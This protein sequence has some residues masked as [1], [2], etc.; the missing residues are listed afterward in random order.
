VGNYCNVS[1]RDSIGIALEA[2]KT[3]QLSNIIY[4]LNT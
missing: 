4:S 1:T 2:D 3:H